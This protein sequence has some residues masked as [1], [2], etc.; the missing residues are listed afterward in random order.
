MKAI[1]IGTTTVAVVAVAAGAWWMTRPAPNKFAECGATAVAGEA[2]IG[3]PFTLVSETGATVTDTD[4]ISAPTLLYFG[5]TF[6]PDVCPVDSARNAEAIDI[7]D[8][9]GVEVQPVFVSIDPKRDTPEIVGD[10]T[11]LFHPRMLG[12]TGSAEQVA[13][14]SRAYR[15]YYRAEETGDDYYLVDHS[16]FTYL[17]LP[18]EGFVEFFRREDTPERIADVTACYV[19]AAGA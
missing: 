12:L 18:G 9:R 6:C 5:Y 14:A 17:V 16:T 13:A 10:Y 3:G 7:L 1:L 11:D 2:N 4:V 19:N 15:T 8:G